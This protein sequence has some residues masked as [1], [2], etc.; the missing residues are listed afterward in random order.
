MIKIGNLRGFF[1]LCGKTLSVYGT[2]KENFRNL[3]T[4]LK[5]DTFVVLVVTTCAKKLKIDRLPIRV[6]SLGSSP[7]I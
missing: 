7:V 2:S 1:S 3:D 4:S 5:R 6:W